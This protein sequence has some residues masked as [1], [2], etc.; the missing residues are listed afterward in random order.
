M[1]IVFSE[2][3]YKTCKL[4]LCK[5]FGEA[6][7]LE[8]RQLLHSSVLESENLACNKVL[9]KTRNFVSQNGV[10]AYA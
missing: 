2:I 3:Y 4:C 1:Q 7:C 10:A 6:E 5:I 9:L 8:G